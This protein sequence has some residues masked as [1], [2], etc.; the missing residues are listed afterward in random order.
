MRHHHPRLPDSAALRPARSR[1]A[2][3]A[4]PGARLHPAC[5]IC[6]AH[7]ERYFE[8]GHVRCR[9]VACA[10]PDHCCSYRHPCCRQD[11]IAGM[12]YRG[13]GRV[14]WTALAHLVR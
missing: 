12:E 1:I 6:G 5:G 13:G 4:R 2:C 7:R 9:I 11:E 3:L 8:S 14:V 10:D